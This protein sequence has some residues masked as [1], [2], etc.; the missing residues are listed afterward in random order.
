MVKYNCTNWV[1]RSQMELAQSYSINH[2][3]RTRQE[4]VRNYIVFSDAMMSWTARPVSLQNLRTLVYLLMTLCFVTLFN[5]SE[6]K[7]MFFLFSCVITAS[8]LKSDCHQKWYTLFRLLCTYCV[9]NFSLP[10]FSDNNV[11]P[12][13]VNEFPEMREVHP[14]F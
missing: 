11:C 1:L 4:S 12:Y 7:N 2:S 14:F 13:S 9:Q 10:M 3:H 5:L 8:P 6:K